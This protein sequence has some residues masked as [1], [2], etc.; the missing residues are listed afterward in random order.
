[1]HSWTFD[2]D[3]AAELIGSAYIKYF[4]F[5][6]EIRSLP[7]I[8]TL[9][10]AKAPDHILISNLSVQLCFLMD[11]LRR[12]SENNCTDIL[13]LRTCSLLV[14]MIENEPYAS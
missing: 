3:A 12:M 9:P 10:F 2:R 13:T 8:I 6:K 5:Y 4:E 11:R 1:M 7:G 14:D